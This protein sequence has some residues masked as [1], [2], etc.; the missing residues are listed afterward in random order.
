MTYILDS[1][2]IKIQHRFHIAFDLLKIIF[3]NHVLSV[4]H[5]NLKLFD[6]KLLHLTHCFHFVFPN[7][8]INE[9]YITSSPHQPL[10]SALVMIIY[11]CNKVNLFIS[12]IYFFI[13][14]MFKHIFFVVFLSFLFSGKCHFSLLE[15]RNI[16][17][18]MFL[19]LTHQ[20]THFRFSYI[21]DSQME[22]NFI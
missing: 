15:L 16:H 7:Y 1:K 22:L 3:K 21:S 19:Y 5:S 14:L 18:T 17:K 12:F 4:I 8:I 6:Q 2:W 9:N 11:K 10:P 20:R 13:I